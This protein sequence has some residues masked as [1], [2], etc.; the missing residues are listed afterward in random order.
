V[1][2]S[3]GLLCNFSFS[4]SIVIYTSETKKVPSCRK[5]E[6]ILLSKK[7]DKQQQF[8][9]KISDYVNKELFG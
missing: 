7:V 1:Y 6:F 4:G 8:S 2:L 3:A 5:D 9:P